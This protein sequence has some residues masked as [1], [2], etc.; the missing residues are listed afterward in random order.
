MGHLTAENELE[1]KLWIDDMGAEVELAAKR[2][3]GELDDSESRL[4]TE[5][6]HKGYATVDIGDVSE[7]I[8]ALEREVSELWRNPPFDLSA[9]GPIGRPLP[10]KEI[11]PDLPRGP[12]V[13]ILDLHSHSSGALELYLNAKVH[14][15]VGLILGK[16]AVATQSLFFEYGSTQALHRDPWY[17]NHTPRTHLVAAWFALEDVHPD[18]GP[19]RYVPGSHRMP[20]YRFSTNDV[21]FHDPRVTE[22]ERTAALAH[23]DEQIAERGLK[24]Q[25]ALPRKGQVFLWHGSLVHGGS[26][27]QNPA[28]TRK[29]LVVHYGRIDTHPNRGVG[30][31]RDRV[32]RVF[33]T[34]QKYRHPA[35]T[36]GFHNPFQGKTAADFAAAQ[37]PG[38]PKPVAPTVEA[39]RPPASLPAST[40]P[41]GAATAQVAAP[42]APTPRAVTNRTRWWQS[43]VIC[44]HINRRICGVEVD[45]T[46]GGDIERLKRAAKGTPFPRAVSLVRS[47]AFH[48]LRLLQEGIVERFV[49]HVPEARVAAT[50]AMASS[51]GVADRVTLDSGNPLLR[52]AVPEF[53]LVYWKTLHCMPSAYAAVDWSK[54][55]LRPQGVF[56]VNGFCGPT[57]LQYTDR[58][59]SMAELARRALSESFL[60]NPHDPKRAVVPFRAQRPS[61]TRMVEDDPSNCPDSSGI[62]P[63]IRSLWPDADV[64]PTG[65]IVYSLALEDILTNFGED[66]DLAL[67]RAMLL[68]DDLCVEA[69]ESL[70]CVAFAR[71]G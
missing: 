70:H 66:R 62:L 37:Q 7:N 56:Y 11:A 71:R 63:A 34:D 4:L 33:Y 8:A 46:D 12:G 27:V 41:A 52:E 64:I 25:A 24:V 49:L 15:L 9:A 59:L 28:L 23:M 54:Q 57:R 22:K 20:W 29:S 69:G 47:N 58:Q 14:R 50:Q 36:Q 31:T 48:E 68:A 3:R 21:V 40:L 17:V 42:T 16:Q 51:M 60:A 2:E 39:V 35:G 43:S 19:L 45:G 65:G 13:R 32:T 10:F 6:M 61:V 44:R 67:L 53:D 38:P 5:F 55:V 1:D 26:P 30:L 18:S